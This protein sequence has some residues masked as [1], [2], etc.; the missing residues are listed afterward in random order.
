VIELEDTDI[1]D[2]PAA[3]RLLP[4]FGV[5]LGALLIG[6]ATMGKGFAYLHVPGNIPLYAGE[7]VLLV[8]VFAT[9]V[10][11]R[12]VPSVL[13]TRTGLLYGAFA[14]LGTAR[15]LPFL[16]LYGA[17]ALRDAVLFGYGAFMVLVPEVLDDRQ[18]LLRFA[19][20]YRRL[21]LLY[22]WWVPCAIVLMVY[23]ASSVPLVPGTDVPLL[24]LKPGDIAV[25]LS[26]CAAWFLLVPRVRS[27]GQPPVQESRGTVWFA[28]AVGGTALT[29]S[30]AA[31]VALLAGLA[32]ATPMAGV[33]RMVRPFAGF[34]LAFLIVAALGPTLH[35]R[36]RRQISLDSLGALLASITSGADDTATGGGEGTKQWRLR[37]WEKIGEETLTGP[38]FWGG[39]GFGVNLAN[40]H[41]FQVIGGER[42]LRSPHNSHMTVLA[43]MG[44]PGA[45]LWILLNIALVVR[46]LGARRRALDC[47]DSFLAGILSWTLCYWVAF[48][49]NTSFDV[50]LEGPQSGIWFWSVMGI[51]MAASTV[52]PVPDAL[53]EAAE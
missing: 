1:P 52:E 27:S 40:V 2:R 38:Y 14:L 32:A 41:G 35:P 19:G 15:T 50:F 45:I 26:A 28:L 5:A 29:V 47:D 46:F 12:F 49:V 7:I 39:R 22:P 8:G 10:N 16:G 23:F 44:V 25:N 48:T 53:T 4:A 21:A 24:L 36:A 3:R 34:V 43:R 20:V 51:G 17:D 18:A 9:A 13:R 37:W 6:Y 31:Y 42:S 33:R 11:L 30:R